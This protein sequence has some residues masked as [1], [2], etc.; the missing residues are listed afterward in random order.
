MKT[1]LFHFRFAAHSA[2]IA[3]ISAAAFLLLAGSCTV[4]SKTQK[5]MA[6]RLSISAD[7][8]VS[9]PIRMFET[10][11]E[12]RLERSLFYA[13]TLTGATAHFS[14]VDM[15]ADAAEKEQ[16]RLSKYGVYINALNSY[17]RAIQ[18]L[19]SDTRWKGIGTEVRGIG[20]N[21][22][23][24]LLYY[25]KIFSDSL[26]VGYFKI[27]GKAG[28][29]ISEELTKGHQA[30]LLKEFMTKGDSIVSICCDSLI[31]VLK[32]D[33]LIELIDNE[34]AALKYDYSRFLEFATPKPEILI[35]YDRRY[36]HLS[37]S[38]TTV[39]SLRTQCCRG[40]KAFQKAHSSLVKE[41][42]RKKD[43]DI[44]PD[45][46]ELIKISSQICLLINKL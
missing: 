3:T 31:A 37:A 8:V 36:V 45:L 2:T 26:S 23:S 19:S 41:M 1:T 21:L 25:D 22:D 38:M 10:L 39:K 6:Q 29:Y 34:E 35:E 28:G 33:A 43:S 4:L 27:A 12:V 17:I 44:Y 13:S 24:I 42:N 14:E 32:S 16:K 30:K 7:T 40:L 11:A 5:A 9:A 18:S 20:N 15:I 46:L